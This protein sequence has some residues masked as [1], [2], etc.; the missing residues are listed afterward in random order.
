[1][2]VFLYSMLTSPEIEVRG[3]AQESFFRHTDLLSLPR[4]RFGGQSPGV[5]GIG[6]AVMAVVIVTAHRC[7]GW[8]V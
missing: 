7:G 5:Q 4:G 3:A 2:I 1:M 8:Q 6:V